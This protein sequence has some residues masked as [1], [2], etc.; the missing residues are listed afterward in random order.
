L[1]SQKNT[2]CSICGGNFRGETGLKHHISIMHSDVDTSIRQKN[3]NRKSYEN[4]LL[5]AQKYS[6]KKIK[7]TI[8]IQCPFCHSKVNKD[9]LKMH[10]NKVHTEE[11]KNRVYAGQKPR[12]IKKIKEPPSSRLR[13][14]KSQD[15]LFRGNPHRI[16]HGEAIQPTRPIQK[17]TPSQWSIFN[18][19]FKE[20]RIQPKTPTF[21][22]I[23]D[24][25]IWIKN[26]IKTQLCSEGS[27]NETRTVTI[28]F[29]F[30]TSFSKVIIGF[31][32]KKVIVSFDELL[33]KYHSPYMIPSMVT[34]DSEESYHLGYCKNS[35][36]KHS[37]L[38]I[39]L[40][41][42]DI[43]PIQK[44]RI[45]GYIALV[46]RFS[47]FW[48]LNK[49]FNE[50]KSH[51]IIWFLNVGVPTK[52]WHD[53]KL[54]EEYLNLVVSS[55]NLSVSELKIN[56]KNI[57]KSLKGEITPKNMMYPDEIGLIPE[58]LSQIA[59]YLD[60]PKRQ[61]DLHLIIDIGGGTVDIATFTVYGRIDYLTQILDAKISLQGA[62]SLIKNRNSKLGIDTKWE[63]FGPIPTVN[64][65]SIVTT[66]PL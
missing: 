27:G 4:N 50:N 54:K 36:E 45:V 18:K 35:K 24:D 64:H 29:D 20:D 44:Q 62:H 33:E 47:R 3:L 30:G 40:L 52:S 49:Y 16:R 9:N 19:K 39:P 38:K 11:S 37:L 23:D 7:H 13:V 5:I 43:Q 55:W 8:L 48:F 60:S 66:D 31:F 12:I 41:Y 61:D 15:R 10:I 42:G 2:P 46:L 25:Y 21:K 17:N 22:I 57:A 65:T 51:D 58:F 26:G 53:N 63:A 28:G 6:A 1:R 32:G 14:N 34:I 56:T 59:A